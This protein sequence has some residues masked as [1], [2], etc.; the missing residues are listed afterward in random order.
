[1]VSISNSDKHIKYI[2]ICF[3]CSVIKK[4][5]Y[6]N[7][8]VVKRIIK[9]LSITPDS[10][11]VRPVLHKASD[12]VIRAICNAALNARE[13]DVRIPPHL[14]H[15]FAKY[16]RHIHRLTDH[17][18]P[19]SKKRRLHVQPGGVL[20]IIGSLIATVLGSIGGEFITR[21]FNKN[22]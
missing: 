2:W 21:L 6:N 7:S 11:V 14:K 10:K 8:K 19:L 13:G 20:P 16:L 15:I 5:R 1:M 4:K 18:C 3:I 22:E 17:R 12:S 9:F